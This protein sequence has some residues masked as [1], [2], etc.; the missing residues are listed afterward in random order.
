MKTSPF[1]LA[2]ENWLRWTFRRIKAGAAAISDQASF[3]ID[4]AFNENIGTE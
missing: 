1:R 3:E 2:I 4:S